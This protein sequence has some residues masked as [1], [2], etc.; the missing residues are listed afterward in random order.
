MV[1]RAALRLGDQSRGVRRPVEV[2]L[3]RKGAKKRTHGRKLRSTGTKARARV[4]QR[5]KPRADPGQQLEKYKRDL[6]E[7][8]QQLAEA[9]EQQTATSEV[10]QVIGESPGELEPVFNAMLTNATRICEAKFGN[11]FLRD[12]DAFRFVAQHNAPQAWL[13]V[14]RR[15][16]YPSRSGHRPWAHRHDEASRPHRRYQDRARLYRA[17]S[18]VGRRC[19]TCGRS[20]VARRADAQGRTI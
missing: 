19:R 3:S 2:I 11:L 16:P 20:D 1:E 6:A 17:G 5:R 7:A 13:D 12:G 9:L 18:D 14:R 10:L 15:D 8:Q 4:G